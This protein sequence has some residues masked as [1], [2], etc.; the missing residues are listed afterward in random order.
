MFQLIAAVISIALVAVLAIASTYYGGSAFTQAQQ[1]AQITSLINTAEQ[2]A[3]AYALY[4]TDW[5][6]ARLNVTTLV[7]GVSGNTYLASYPATDTAAVTGQWQTTSSYRNA[8]IPLAYTGAQLT[9]FCQAI[10]VQ[11]GAK[12]FTSPGF[13]AALY[14]DLPSGVQF[15]CVGDV[16]SGGTFQFLVP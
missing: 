9:K 3:G 10:A 8:I 7:T 15:G 1:K 4:T 16:V 11:A 5:G 2:I 6:L 12:A 14:D 13:V